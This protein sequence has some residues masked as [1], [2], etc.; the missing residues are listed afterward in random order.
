MAP[1][2][3]LRPKRLL[4]CV[5]CSFL[6]HFASTFAMNFKAA[7]LGFGS[8]A[9]RRGNSKN[10]SFAS[11]RIKFSGFRRFGKAPKHKAK[12]A[13][14]R[15]SRPVFFATPRKLVFWCILAPFWSR[16]PPEKPRKS[17]QKKATNLESNLKL[18][19]SLK[20]GSKIA[21]EASWNFKQYFL[22]D[23]LQK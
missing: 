7:L 10:R 8:S 19:K 12:T 14:T 15:G 22:S 3:E 17:S 4:E 23:F 11:A 20:K 16:K 18:Q 21:G 2:R 5:L 6:A 9:Q 13:P 1:R